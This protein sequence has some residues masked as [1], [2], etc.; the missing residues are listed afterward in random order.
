MMNFYLDLSPINASE[1]P[2]VCL[3]CSENVWTSSGGMDLEPIWH[4]SNSKLIALQLHYFACLSIFALALHSDFENALAERL[5]FR[6]P[7]P[8]QF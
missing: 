6:F 3:V 2:E 4:G 5:S 8:F 7:F 1:W